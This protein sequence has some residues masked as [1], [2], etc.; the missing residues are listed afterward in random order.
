M[1][2]P[3]DLARRFTGLDSSGRG[4]LERLMATW[5][6][7][8]DLSFS[9]LLLYVPVDEFSL[10]EPDLAG[11]RPAGS[12]PLRGLH[13]V[14]LGQI[15][16]TT[17]QTLH[18]QDLVGEVVTAS[19]APLV[20]AAWRDGVVSR[21]QDRDLP[22]PGLVEVECVPVRWRG[23]VVAV[24]RRTSSPA[25]GRSEGVLEATYLELYDRFATMIG[26]GMFP[27]V[28]DDA[29]IEEAPRV[30][31]GAMIV[32]PHARIGFASPNAVSALHRMGVVTAATGTTL[33][34]LGMRV[35]AVDQALASR[36]PAIQE[37]ERDGEVIVLFRCIP[38][39]ASGEVTGAVVLLRDI[40]DLRR[41]DR[42]LLSKDAAI[43]E[44]HHRVKNNLQTISSLLRLQA[45]RVD[46]SAPA[47][48]LL[49]AERRIRS[50]ALVHELL[51]RESGDQVP[52][53][54][55]VHSLVCM[56]R[57]S[58]VTTAPLTLRVAGD[59]GKVAT[60]I[61][62]PLA[63][64]LAELLQNAVEHAFVAPADDAGAQAHRLSGERAAGEPRVAQVDV[65]FRHDPHE[66]FVEV[67]DNGCGLPP[68]F[69]LEKSTGLGLALVRDLVRSQLGGTI[70][71]STDHGTVMRL[72]V[73]LRAQPVRGR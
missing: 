19:A 56:A 23:E 67:R 42:L 55:I 12:G 31:D 40:T 47:E 14:V 18:D 6:L 44:V 38:L 22:G 70:S 65:V 71:P 50:M 72:S 48:A 11:G 39:I 35:A 43:R 26:D 62:T 16:P 73:P 49:E 28:S 57:D 13:F 5:G 1:T 24:L 15:R 30:G 45:R 52:F 61:A 3:V 64:V 46:G 69:D 36:L 4:H 53:D 25:L 34:S 68:G 59:A 33:A 54:E 17:S 32:D 66:L 37:V 21:G 9:D 27:F 10:S 63:V 2:V 41:R 20:V 7:L 51:S 60:D 8:A 29:A 58:N